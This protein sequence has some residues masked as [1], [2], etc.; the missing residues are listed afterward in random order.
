V[1][2]AH[3]LGF[4]YRSPAMGILGD[5]LAYEL[6]RSSSLRTSYLFNALVFFPIEVNGRLQRPCHTSTIYHGWTGDK[7]VLVGPRHFA[8]SAIDRAARQ[9]Q[10]GEG[11]AKDHRAT[12]GGPAPLS[13]AAITSDFDMLDLVGR[14]GLE[15][16]TYGLKVR[17]STD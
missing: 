12:D 15:P 10:C 5:S 11:S 13:L 8:D 14:A 1:A 2:G 7:N 16:A 9:T 6:G 3:A 17:S 4:A